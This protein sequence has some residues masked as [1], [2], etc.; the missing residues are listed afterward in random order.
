ML[1]L[2]R[3]RQTYMPFAVPRERTQ[4]DVYN[5]QLRDAYAST[6]R[7]APPAPSP[8][9]ARRRDPFADLK[10][11]AQLHESGVLTD[12]EFATAKAKIL[13]SSADST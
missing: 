10:E 1:F 8:A 4:Q 5:R 6:R 9:P 13:D 2:L 7:V 11:V 12:D 3:P